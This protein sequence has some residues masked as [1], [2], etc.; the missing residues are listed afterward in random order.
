MPLLVDFRVH[1]TM[2]KPGKYG[3]IL[4]AILAIVYSAEC[5]ASQKANRPAAMLPILVVLFVVS[6]ALLTML[7]FEQGKT[8]EAQRTLIREMLK[9]STQLA[10]IKG[11]LATNDAQHPQDKAAAQAGQ[12]ASGSAAASKDAGK[13][14]KKAGKA[15]RSMRQAPGRPPADLE[16]IRRSTNVI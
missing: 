14:T 13:D 11:K 3:A 7:V 9:D 15:P 4:G 2:S 6:Y 10:A 8:I 16:D 12:K 1:Y 5:K